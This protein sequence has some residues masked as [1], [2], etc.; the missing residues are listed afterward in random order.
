MTISNQGD[1]VRYDIGA[2]LP[3]TALGVV[4]MTPGST[5]ALGT[6]SNPLVTQTSSLQTTADLT[7]VIVASTTIAT[8]PIVTAAASVRA[9]IYRLRIDVAGANVLTFVDAT[10][11]EEMNFAGA[12]FRI[13]DFAT[14]PWFTSAVNTAFSVTTTTTAKVNIVAE[15]TRVA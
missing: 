1:V 7:K 13:Y 4:M 10:G 8:T 11:T 3:E 9:R 2:P 12:G 5:G 14:R 6:A 15:Y